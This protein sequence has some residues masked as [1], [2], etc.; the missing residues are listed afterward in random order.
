[1]PPHFVKSA[2]HARNLTDEIARDNALSCKTRRI[3]V[4]MPAFSARS[5]SHPAR[6]TAHFLS[7]NIPGEERSD[8]GRAPRTKNNAP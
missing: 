3:T 7:P 5:A 2:A 1:M 6:L 8:G 4:Q